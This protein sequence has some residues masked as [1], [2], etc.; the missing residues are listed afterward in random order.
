MQVQNVAYEYLERLEEPVSFVD[1]HLHLDLFAAPN[2]IIGES[3]SRGIETMITAGGS[4]RSNIET[5]KLVGRNGV[6]GVV[7]ISPDFAD[8]EKERLKEVKDVIM[9]SPSI[10]GIGEIG[11]DRKISPD[12]HVQEEVFRE[13][14]RLAKE[15]D[16][17]VVIHSRKAI[18]EVITIMKE[19]KVQRAMMHFFEGDVQEVE[20]LSNI[21]FLISISPGESSKKKRVIRNVSIDKIVAESDSPAAAK[22][23]WSVI[24]TYELIA[25][26]KGL[27][28]RECAYQI[29]ENI[30][31]FFQI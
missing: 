28:I 4:M 24:D 20:K 8:K 2:E 7:G 13:Q 21:K 22:F 26:I 14:L 16:L 19:E 17:P 12:L 1:A 6:F 10:V 9:K 31:N 27:S 30:K 29:Q 11:L 5:L 18:E 3:R 15:L 25:K 23:P